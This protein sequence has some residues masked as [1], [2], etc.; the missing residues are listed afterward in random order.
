VLC[1]KVKI[2]PWHTQLTQRVGTGITPTHLQPST[3]RQVVSIALRPFYPQERP[4]THC[5]GGWVELG[6]GL[7]RTENLA[8][9]VIRSLD[10]PAIASH[11]TNYVIPAAFVLNITYFIFWRML[12][13]P[14]S[15]KQRWR[16][17]CA[18]WS[19]TCLHVDS[20]ILPILRSALHCLRHTLY[21][22]REFSGC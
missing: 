21:M 13:Y 7:D 9:T 20:C 4:S 10:C 12:T 5:T 8:P 14:I 17:R 3:K 6:A 1:I 18:C 16:A 2:T 19:T 11:E 15:W 22:R